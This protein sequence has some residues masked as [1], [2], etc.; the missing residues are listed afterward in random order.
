MPRNLLIN[1][2]WIYY[3]DRD[4][5]LQKI[6]TKPIRFEEETVI[7]NQLSDGMKIVAKNIPGAFIGMKVIPMEEK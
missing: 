3:I 2:Q 7:T 5:T 4:S 1:N 6:E